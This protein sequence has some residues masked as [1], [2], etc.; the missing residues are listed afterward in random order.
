M[1][2]HAHVETLVPVGIQRLLHDAGR[3]G[4]LSI[5]GDHRKGIR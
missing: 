4:L 3:V 1:G 2:T 5:D